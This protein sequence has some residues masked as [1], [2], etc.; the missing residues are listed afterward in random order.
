MTEWRKVL[1]FFLDLIEGYNYCNLLVSNERLWELFGL[2]V[3]KPEQK[4]E[5]LNC[6]IEDKGHTTYYWPTILDK[7]RKDSKIPVFL[8]VLIGEDKGTTAFVGDVKANSISKC[9][10][11]CLHLGT[12][13]KENI[14]QRIV[15]FPVSMTYDL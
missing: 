15:V 14:R 13:D 2:L 7:N 12:H 10:I 6:F 8:F 1:V 4:D 5:V 9:V 11:I 3:K